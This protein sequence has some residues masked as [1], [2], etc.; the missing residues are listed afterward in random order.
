MLLTLIAVVIFA[1]CLASLWRDGLWSNLVRLLN[2]L[3]AGWLASGCYEWVAGFVKHWMPSALYL[4]DFAALWLLFGAGV[5]VLCEITDRLSRYRLRFPAIIDRAGGWSLAAAIGALVVCFAFMTLHTA[6][7]AEHFLF[8]QFQPQERMV[9]GLAPD[10][11]WLG[12]LRW[13]AGGTLARSDAPTARPTPPLLD[14]TDAFVKKY[15]EQR[16]AL[17]RQVRETGS[18]MV[19]R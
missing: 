19:E 6:P 18:L 16:A 12:F 11:A 14:S 7:L 3:V 17:E 4:A 13:T 5:A 1:A 15:A 10:R 9:L 8:G 2:V